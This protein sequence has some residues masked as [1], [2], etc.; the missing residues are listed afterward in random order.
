MKYQMMEYASLRQLSSEKLEDI[1]SSVQL[2]LSYP[3]ILP[4]QLQIKLDTLH[5]DI[6]AVLEDR[7]DLGHDGS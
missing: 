1:M 6:T 7:N 2:L 4:S 3:D 5:A